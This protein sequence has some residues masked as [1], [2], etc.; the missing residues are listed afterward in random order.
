VDISETGLQISGIPTRFGDTKEFLVQADYFADVLPFVIE[1]RCQWASKAESGRLFSG[2]EITS[3]S[4]QA[5]EE[6]KKLTRA[7]TLGG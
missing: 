7:L 4:K 6:L 5:F 1:A 3:I 2:F